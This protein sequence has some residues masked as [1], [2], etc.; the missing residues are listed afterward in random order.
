ML[1]GIIPITTIIIGL[2]LYYFPPKNINSMYGYRSNRSM[3]DQDSW[4]Y[5]QKVSGFISVILGAAMLAAT[6]IAYFILKE[7][8]EFGFYTVTTIVFVQLGAL[9]LGTLLPVELLLKKRGRK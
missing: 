3:Q 5:A 1:I 4:D 9:V 6:I 8:N 2:I 7:K